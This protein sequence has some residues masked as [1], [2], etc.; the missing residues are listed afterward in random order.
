M[1]D[2]ISVV[3]N[4][5][6]GSSVDEDTLRSAFEA[7]GVETKWLSTT[8]D[9]PGTGQG[10]EAAAG[11]SATVVAC[12]GD[13]TVRAVLQGVA[14]HDVP[15]GI[16]PLGTG[17]LLASN[18]GLPSGVDAVPTAVTGAPKL[19][20]LG[21]VNDERFAV[22]AG[23]GF[24]ATMI[25]ETS[26]SLKRKVGPLAY[27]LTAARNLGSLRSKVFRVTVTVDDTTWR[28]RSALVL[29]GN[30][31]TVTGGLEVFPDAVPD[32]GILDVAILSARGPRQWMSVLWR[33]LR[34]R[35][36]RPDLVHRMRGTNVHVR[37]D[38][39]VEYELDGEVRPATTDLHFTI[40]PAALSVRC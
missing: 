10:A 34:H 5:A 29:V 39:A 38:R 9:D 1:T 35:S 32:D 30:C 7:T 2:F 21:V 33:L 18:L 15:M 14:G 28:G 37:L 8:E 16:V 31:G 26:S 22:M 13:G 3:V 20:D 6:S 23:V 11:G 19:M 24:D 40:E 4:S 25:G 17:N 27:V 12:G 36:Q